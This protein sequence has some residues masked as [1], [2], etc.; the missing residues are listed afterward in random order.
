MLVSP[1]NCFCGATME[2]SRKDIAPA[3]PSAQPEI[4]GAKVFA[5]VQGT[6]AEPRAAYLDQVVPLRAEIV[7]LA[8]PVSPTEVFR[9]SAPCAAR[10]CCHFGEGRCSLAGRLVQLLPPVVVAA[11]PCMLRPNCMWW[12]QEGVAACLRCPQVVTQMYSASAEMT[13]AATPSPKQ[14]QLEGSGFTKH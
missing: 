5:V 2:H 11:P 4:N 8:A 12:L 10:G 13:K 14:P 6:A 7:A 1:C 3:C 9:I